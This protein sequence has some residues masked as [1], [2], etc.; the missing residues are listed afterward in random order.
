LCWLVHLLLPR[1][2]TIARPIPDLSLTLHLRL[3]LRLGSACIICGLCLLRMQH[4]THEQNQ[5]GNRTTCVFG[6]IIHLAFLHLCVL[7]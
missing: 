3:S 5:A 2:L 4:A 1:L 6:Y 7:E